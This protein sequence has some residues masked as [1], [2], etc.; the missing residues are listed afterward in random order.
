M[1]TEEKA[2]LVTMD[3][4]EAIKQLT[5][6]EGVTEEIALSVLESYKKNQTIRSAVEKMN[7]I[8]IVENELFKIATQGKM[9]D[10]NGNEVYSKNKLTAIN[11]ILDRFYGRAIAHVPA[12]GK[13][14]NSTEDKISP[15]INLSP[16]IMS[17][18]DKE[19]FKKNIK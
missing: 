15:L 16:G 4:E 19:R 1:N 7:E 10:N 13:D 11:N 6:T 2:L 18:K 14:P 12:N 9:V 17:D 3:E 8:K 5:Q